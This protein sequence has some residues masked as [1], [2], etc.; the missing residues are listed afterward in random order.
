MTG[1]ATGQPPI[2]EAQFQRQVLDLARILGWAAYHPMLSKWSERGWPDVCLVKPPRLILAE[3]KRENGKTTP[4][5]DRW[6]EMLRAC[7]GVE[8]YLWRPSDLDGIAR[9]LG[10]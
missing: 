8:T 9:C 10:A 5:Q 3:L 7:P 1:T 4:H 2:S 6:L